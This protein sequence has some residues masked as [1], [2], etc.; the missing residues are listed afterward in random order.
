MEHLHHESLPPKTSLCWGSGAPLSFFPLKMPLCI[1]SNIVLSIHRT[2]PLSTL[3]QR[4]SKET[5]K[6]YTPRLMEEKTNAW[7]SPTKAHCSDRKQKVEAK[8]PA[9]FSMLYT[10]LWKTGPHRTPNSNSGRSEG[11]PSAKQ[12]HLECEHKQC[13]RNAGQRLTTHWWGT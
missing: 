2:F 10:Q 12:K 1:C 13:R 9:L 4:K 11:T 3:V 5:F 7:R 8:R 6:L